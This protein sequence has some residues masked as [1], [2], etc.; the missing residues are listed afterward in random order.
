MEVFAGAIRFMTLRIAINPATILSPS[1]YTI[2]KFS[3]ERQT[4]PHTPIRI[5]WF[6]SHSTPES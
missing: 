5:G 1:R 3:V 4:E 2:E 6:G